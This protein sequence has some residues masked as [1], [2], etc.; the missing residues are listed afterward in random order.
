MKVSR[1]KSS[2][3]FFAF[4]A[5]KVSSLNTTQVLLSSRALQVLKEHT[6]QRIHIYTEYFKQAVERSN[7]F[8]DSVASKNLGI[9]GTYG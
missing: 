5:G 1:K 2:P 9:M 8:F 3:R 4:A 7:Q 6:F